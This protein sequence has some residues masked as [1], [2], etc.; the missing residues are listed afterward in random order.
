MPTRNI[1]VGQKVT[2]P[3]LQRA[4]ELRRH[5]TPE[6]AM[7]W[8]RL[9]ANRL[10]GFHFRRQQVIAG[11]IVDFYCHSAGLV[12]EV[13]GS[14]HDQR[15]EYDLD[16]SRILESLGLRV[17]RFKNQEIHEEIE[18]VLARVVAAC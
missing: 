16:R 10:Q 5:M 18:G 17:L 4:K 7:L 1:V 11:F 8:E 6:E 15:V 9:R 3:K 12:I 13:D 14:V 2:P